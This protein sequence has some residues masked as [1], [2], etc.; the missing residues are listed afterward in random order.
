MYRVLLAEDEI[1][2]RL[3]LK[4]SIDWPRYDIQVNADVP[5]GAEAW[6]A[7]ERLQPEVIITD[8]KMPIMGG[9]EL[10]SKIRSVNPHNLREQHGKYVLD[11]RQS[12]GVRGNGRQSRAASFLC[13]P[14]ACQ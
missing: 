8:L 6:S 1:L 5:N 4:N 14:G 13:L 3:G 2:V 12:R 11:E 7:Y 10:L 9:L